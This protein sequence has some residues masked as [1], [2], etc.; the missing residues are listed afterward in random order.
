MVSVFGGLSSF[1]ILHLSRESE[2]LLSF[3]LL[4]LRKNI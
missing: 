4:S 3:F 1:F 2:S